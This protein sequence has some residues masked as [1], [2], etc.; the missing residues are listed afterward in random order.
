M[1]RASVEEIGLQIND[2]ER[3]NY[4]TKANQGKENKII[5]KKTD[6]KMETKK[7]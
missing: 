7:R 5:M 3:E 6:Y 4:P 2:S 1:A